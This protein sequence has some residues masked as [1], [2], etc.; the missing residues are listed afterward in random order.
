MSSRNVCLQQL[1]WL[2]PEL[3]SQPDYYCVLYIYIYIYIYIY[4][5]DDAVGS[6][7]STASNAGYS[8]NPRHADWCRRVKCGRETDAARQAFGRLAYETLA[9]RYGESL[10][11]RTMTI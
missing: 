9:R 2:R 11:A 8:C 4:T 3:S 6:K 10:E 5:L 1:D 7:M